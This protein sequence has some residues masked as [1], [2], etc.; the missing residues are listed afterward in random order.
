VEMNFKWRRPIPQRS[1]L[2]SIGLYCFW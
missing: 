1:V 2:G